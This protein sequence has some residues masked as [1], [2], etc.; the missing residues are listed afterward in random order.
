M[1]GEIKIMKKS[2]LCLAVFSCLMVTSLASCDD[3]KN[4]SVISS[5]TPISSETSSEISSST[6]SSSSSTEETHIVSIEI[7]GDVD[8]TYTKGGSITI[9]VKLDG[10]AATSGASL[11]ASNDCVTI[12]EGIAGIYSVSLVKAGKVTFTAKVSKNNKEY[13]ET[14]TITILD[15]NIVSLANA[16]T[17]ADGEIVTVQGKV[18]AVSGSSAYIADSTGGMYIYNLH[19]DSEDTAITNKTWTLGA[20]V[21]VKAKVASYSGLKQLSNYDSE[22]KTKISGTYAKTISNDI[23]YTPI[24][25]DE[26]GFNT[27]KSTD[28]GNVYTFTATYVSGTPSTGN[29][30]SVKFK[31]GSTNIILRTDKY[32]KVGISAELVEN[33]EYK[34]TTPLSWHDGAQFAFLGVGTSIESSEVI[35]PTSITCSSA[36]STIMVGSS[37]TLSYTLSPKGAI[38]DV[39]YEI[40]EGSDVISLSGNSVTALK[41][42][43]AKV[44]AKCGDLVSDPISITVVEKTIS[45]IS[46]V[47]GTSSQFS[48][49]GVVQVITTKGLIIADDTCAINIHLYEQ[50]T[51]YKVG[52]YINVT[53]VPATF[54]NV[55]QFTKPTITTASGDKPNL[56]D[57]VT[58]TSTIADSFKNDSKTNTVASNK[59]YTWDTTVGKSNNYYTLNVTGSS[60]VIEPCYTQL[61]LTEGENVTVTGYFLGYDYNYNY[62]SFGLVS[63]TAK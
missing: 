27:L 15:S 60:I 34:I 33:R 42:G 49:N 1:K 13:S 53:G 21:E 59:L 50:P 7:T 12:G 46:E 58:L 20:N 40:S 52:D 10:A 63:V 26:A 38:G 37:T 47:S 8:G 32:D 30:V 45:K 11:T 61:S 17:L 31:L 22:N 56:A 51:A 57:A 62:A 18:T 54:H 19:Y 2:V 14:K 24:D 29:N 55:Y 23:N 25:L 41:T 36:L 39:S 9:N 16:K 28:A 35:S 48:V 3:N 44:I 43:S 4:S 6:T 5:E